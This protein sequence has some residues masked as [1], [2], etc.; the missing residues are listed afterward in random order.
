MS[1]TPDDVDS[2]PVWRYPGNGAGAPRS[3]RAALHWLLNLLDQLRRRRAVKALSNRQLRD[4]GIDLTE[5]GRG[6][7]AAVRLDPRIDDLR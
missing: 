1:T 5:A 2:V 7:A 3:G 4:A 6:R